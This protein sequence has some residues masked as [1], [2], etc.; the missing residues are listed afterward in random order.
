M[1]THIC[2]HI[3]IYIYIYAHLLQVASEEPLA[4]PASLKIMHIVAYV[5]E[6]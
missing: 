6:S 2:I 4:L 1:S 3:Y 5:Y